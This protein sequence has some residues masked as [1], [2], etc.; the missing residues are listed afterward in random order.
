VN[1]SAPETTPHPKTWCKQERRQVIVASPVPLSGKS[2]H[3]RLSTGIKAF[4]LVL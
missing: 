3:D 1:T 4:V 2:H